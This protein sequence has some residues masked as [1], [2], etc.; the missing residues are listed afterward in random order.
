MYFSDF[1]RGSIGYC[2]RSAKLYIKILLEEWFP[3]NA[4]ETNFGQNEAASKAV[5]NLLSTVATWT[6]VMGK[7]LQK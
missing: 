4:E 6:K 1:T 2:G 7:Q 3:K 5:L